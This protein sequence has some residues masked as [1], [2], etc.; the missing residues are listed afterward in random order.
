MIF[1]DS[2]A[3]YARF[4]RRDQFHRRAVSAWR[5]LEQGNDRLYTSNFVLDELLTLL[6][7]RV[8]YAFAAERGR[9]IY[10]SRSLEIVRPDAPAEQQA[11]EHFE[12]YADQRVSFTDCVSFVLTK[13]HGIRRAFSFDRHF[14]LA[15]FSL[16]PKR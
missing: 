5:D 4:D 9:S 12:K 6:G 8:G 10:A 13:Q 1:V 11:L 15:G 14:A 7:R 2:G 16:V 3:F